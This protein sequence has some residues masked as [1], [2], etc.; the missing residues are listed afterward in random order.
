MGYLMLALVFRAMLGP[1]GPQ[2]PVP[3]ASL[4]TQYC[5]VQPRSHSQLVVDPG[6]QVIDSHLKSFS[7]IPVGQDLLVQLLEVTNSI[8]HDHQGSQAV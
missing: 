8:G 5:R 1:R 6:Q 7:I 3:V 4:S 2:W